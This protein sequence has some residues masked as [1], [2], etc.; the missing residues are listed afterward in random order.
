MATESAA[1]LL[2][3]VNKLKC[4]NGALG[5]VGATNEGVWGRLC[6][7]PTVSQVGGSVALMFVEYT[8]PYVSSMRVVQWGNSE[9][10]RSWSQPK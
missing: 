7:A 3:W 4:F 6:V 9:I 1:P 10:F 2:S 8:M 5:F